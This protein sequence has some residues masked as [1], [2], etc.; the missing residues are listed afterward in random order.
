MRQALSVTYVA[1]H[2]LVAAVVFGI[3][4]ISAAQIYA[5]SIPH[6]SGI[7]TQ[8]AAV[9]VVQINAL[10]SPTLEC[11]GPIGTYWM[12]STKIVYFDASIICEPPLAY[13]T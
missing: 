2:R 7:L 8:R 9:D 5:T 12:E 13:I 1:A 4:M 10:N 3:C 11:H 6:A